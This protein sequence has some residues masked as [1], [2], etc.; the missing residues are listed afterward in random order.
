MDTQTWEVSSLAPKP[1]GPAPET[2]SHCTGPT[3]HSTQGSHIRHEEQQLLSKAP[4]L[5]SL[6]MHFLSP[7]VSAEHVTAHDHPHTLKM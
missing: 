6:H 4:K 2:E 7:L 5:C 1:L 3:A